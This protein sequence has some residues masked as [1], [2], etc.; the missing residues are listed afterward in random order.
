MAGAN[1]GLE[2][3]QNG[4]LFG[5]GS[6]LLLLGGG[7]VL[8]FVALSLL[9][10]DNNAYAAIAAAMMALAHVV[11]HPHFAHSY[12]IFY[13]EWTKAQK[14]GLPRKLALGWWLVG[15]W[16]PLGLAVSLALGAYGWLNGRGLLL[17]VMVN[18]MGAL[19]GW[20]Y[21]KQGFGMAMVDAAL[22]KRYWPPAAR[23]ALLGN[24][25]VCWIYSWAL[26]NNS[27]AGAYFWGVFHVKANLPEW[28]VLQVGA[29]AA[30]TSAWAAVAV[31]RAFGA[32]REKGHHLK[33]LPVNGLIAYIVSVYLWTVFSGINPAYL[34]VIP[35]FHSLQYLTVV[36]RYKLNEASAGKGGPSVWHSLMQFVLLGAGLGF[37][38]FWGIPGALDWVTK[39]RWPD[40]AAPASIAIAVAWL[41]IN[42]HHY[43]IDT[44][45]WRSG[46]KNVQAHL[47][48]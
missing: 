12:Q 3:R 9:S 31:Y 6:D 25:Y 40:P 11:N 24:A 18:V 27:Q 20:H 44:V 17:G 7:S 43:F 47:F 39:G 28:L 5:P 42:V 22:K 2:F 36:W 13:G 21:V 38:G 16:V 41:F 37:L 33:E 30:C 48:R 29:V 19:V 4:Y 1:V 45:I 10:V 8:V 14:S 46:N 34:L 35:F 32:W 23:K 26:V 15:V